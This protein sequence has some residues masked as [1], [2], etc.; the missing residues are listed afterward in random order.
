LLSHTESLK[1]II[2]L[3]MVALLY[4]VNR[5]ILGSRGEDKHEDDPLNGMNGNDNNNKEK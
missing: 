3:T 1:L 5:W 4:I 2:L